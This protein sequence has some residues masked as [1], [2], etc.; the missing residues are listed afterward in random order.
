MSLGGRK[1]K[2]CWKLQWNQ[3]L[4]QTSKNENKRRARICYAS[5]NQNI[6]EITWWNIDQCH[7]HHFGQRAHP[8]GPNNPQKNL[9]S[10]FRNGQYS[11][12]DRPPNRIWRRNL[13]GWVIIRF[14]I[15]WK[16]LKANKFLIKTL[17]KKK[18]RL[19]L[20]VERKQWMRIFRVECENGGANVLGVGLFRHERHDSAHLLFRKD[21]C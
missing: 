20:C 9:S 13:C 5:I 7:R 19:N 16:R 11:G 12:K 10:I 8:R 14:R 1:S 15:E 17:K 21:G 2:C 6:Y 3:P 18:K 4:V